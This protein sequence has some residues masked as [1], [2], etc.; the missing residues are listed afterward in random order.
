[1]PIHKVKLPDGSVGYKWGQTGKVYKDKK[2]AQ[3]QMQ[4]IYAS[5]WRQHSKKAA[6]SDTD[7]VPMNKK[8]LLQAVL[9]TYMTKSA[10]TYQQ[11]QKRVNDIAKAN[12]TVKWWNPGTWSRN[13]RNKFNP[14]TWGNPSA[15]D[16]NTAVDHREKA[17]KRHVTL[18]TFDKIRKLKQRFQKQAPQLDQLGRDAHNAILQR[19]IDEYYSQLQGRK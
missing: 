16:F 2:D 3:K 4:A 14:F 9:N 17:L 1:M 19:Q 13:V 18:A 6:Q 15:K 12:D 5:G 8:A 7:E 10:A 11:L